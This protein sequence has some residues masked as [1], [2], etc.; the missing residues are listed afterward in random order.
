MKKRLLSAVIML[1][2]F[3]P[4][5]ILGG[6]YFKV[7]VTILGLLAT[8]EILNLKKD[9]L[10]L[11]D[12]LTYIIV[13]SLIFFDMGPIINIFIILLLYNS[14]LVFYDK[15]KYNVNDSGLFISFILL[16][17]MVFTQ[18]Y[19]IREENINILIYLL[20][21]TI[22]TDTFAYIGGRI[23]GK[24]KLIERVSPNKTIEGSIIGSIMGTVFP[25]IFY[26]Y[27]IEP[28]ENIY[29][30][31][32]VSLLLSI[33]GQIGDLIFSSIKRYYKIKDFSNI[34]PG[35]GGILDRLDS[36]I[37]VVVGYIIIFSFI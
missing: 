36:I 33:I 16:I 37:F 11:L 17:I 5:L 14:L 28:G 26:L 29:V 34:I 27:M 31:I 19:L 24:H 15:S 6:I 2:I 32:V 23:F 7:F 18:F 35:H 20:S 30:I 3:I 21:I 13:G 12:I 4:L 22:L 25:T 9:N 8:K 10:V 1:L